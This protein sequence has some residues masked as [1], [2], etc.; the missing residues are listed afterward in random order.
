MLR[1]LRVR[2]RG[3]QAVLGRRGGGGIWRGMGLLRAM[4]GKSE[5][6]GLS[7]LSTMM[8]VDDLTVMLDL[9]TRWLG[10]PGPLSFVLV[11]VRL[12]I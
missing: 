9:V 2:G 12:L 4:Q 3:A 6:G 10:K 5:L 11:F 8:I 1:S 7:E